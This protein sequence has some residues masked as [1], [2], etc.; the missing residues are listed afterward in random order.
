MKQSEIV[1]G[2][3]GCASLLDAKQAQIS[4][5]YYGVELRLDE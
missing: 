5:R 4:Q 2:L 3:L 1:G